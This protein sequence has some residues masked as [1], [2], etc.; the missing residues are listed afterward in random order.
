MTPVQVANLM[1]T[2]ASGRFRPV[3]LVRTDVETPE[4]VIPASAAQWAAIRRGIYGVVNDPTGTAYNYARF[5][6]GAYV[7]CGKTGSATAHRWPTSYRVDYVD[8]DGAAQT[9]LV[10][11]GSKGEAIRRFQV[12]HPFATFDPAAVEV[13]TRWPPCPPP[14]G[15]RY[16]HAWFAGYLQ[17]HDGTGQP[18]WSV[19]PRIAFTVL[20]EFGGSGGRVSGAVAK[21]VAAELLDVFGLDLDVD[22]TGYVDGRP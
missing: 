21:R 22:R 3:T 10:P 19:K 12:E 18:D 11:V 16:S 5:D 9:A 20:I 6:H 2:Y 15:D 1:A 4:W 17:R 8:E 13:A 14:S 7:L